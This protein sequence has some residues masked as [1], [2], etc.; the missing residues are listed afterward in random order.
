M[1]RSA[2][3]SLKSLLLPRL[4]GLESCIRWRTQ[5]A[6]ALMKQLPSCTIH[7]CQGPWNVDLQ[8]PSGP[9]GSS[10][11]SLCICRGHP[12]NL[13]LRLITDDLRLFSRQAIET[14]RQGRQ[15]SIR[16]RQ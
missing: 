1:A 10:G 11:R 9:E 14:L 4:T 13:H 5:A 3:A 16:N 8:T 7:N 6:L 2:V 12:G 15:S